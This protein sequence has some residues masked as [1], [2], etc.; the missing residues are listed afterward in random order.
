MNTW[1]KET[2]ETL[3]CGFPLN[4]FPEEYGGGPVFASPLIG[5]AQGNDSIFEL[6]KKVVG[7]DHLTPAELWRQAELPDRDDLEDQLRVVSV[8][9]PYSQKVREAG[10]KSTGGMPPEIY[11]LARN[12]ANH[13]IAGVMTELAGS[14]NE[15]GFSAA[16][17]VGNSPYNIHLKKDPYRVYSNWSERHIGFAAG[18]GSLGLHAGLITEAGSNIRLGSLVTDAPLEVTPRSSDDPYHNC[19]FHVNG[20]CGACIARCP[21]GAVSE[22]G[23]DKTKCKKYGGKVSVN[24]KKGKLFSLL[25]TRF[26]R[27]NGIDK[28]QRETGCAL[29]QFG[30]PCSDRNPA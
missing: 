17:G 5:V 28:E 9:F 18:L 4:R 11:C 23:H 20:S 22:Q 16:V 29:C 6:F 21:G 3:T 13:I 27:I 30:V 25:R 7:P 2:A 19:L 24:M 12:W 15:Q 26:Q 10:R 8:A 14:L 1:V